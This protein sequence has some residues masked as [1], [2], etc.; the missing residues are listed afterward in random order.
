MRQVEEGMEGAY[1]WVRP[2][3]VPGLCS[4]LCMSYL[5]RPHNPLQSRHLSHPTSKMRKPLRETKK[6]AKVTE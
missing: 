6:L 3:F 1:P 4:G 5:L 2:S